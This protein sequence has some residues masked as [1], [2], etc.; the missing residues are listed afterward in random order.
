MLF[1]NSRM[2]VLMN[3]KD[4]PD[5]VLNLIEVEILNQGRD[6]SIQEVDEVAT[7]LLWR[8]LS[9]LTKSV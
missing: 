5:I 9:K 2:L 7:Y 6:S 1:V 4:T 3:D 8:S